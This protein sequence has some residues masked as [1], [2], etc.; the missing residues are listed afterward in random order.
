MNV[1]RIIRQPGIGVRVMCSLCALALIWL[2][3]GVVFCVAVKG[4]G[5]LIIWI[6]YGTIFFITGWI[7]IGLPVIAMGDRVRRLP[8]LWLAV[9]TGLCGSFII[10][11][12][13][14]LIYLASLSLRPE[15]LVWQLHDLILPG[16]AFL[17]A[18]STA[19]LYRVFLT[20]ASSV[21]IE[22]NS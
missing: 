22:S 13:T 21:H 9:V 4:P 10:E 1:Q 16:T 8:A 17:V 20:K 2:I 12:P 19:V 15:T 11:L 14:L 6:I 5:T 18:A 7:L 3:S